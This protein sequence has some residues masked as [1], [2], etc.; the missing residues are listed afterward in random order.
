[1][2]ETV[3]K[4][5]LMEKETYAI[6]VIQTSSGEIQ[7]KPVQNELIIDAINRLINEHP[8]SKV[9]LFIS[10]VSKKFFVHPNI[11]EWY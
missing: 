11:K 1:M 5:K 4:K 10:N 2:N 8:D 6:I 9:R 7:V 3:L